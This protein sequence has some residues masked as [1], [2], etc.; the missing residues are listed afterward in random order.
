[1]AKVDIVKEKILEKDKKSRYRKTKETGKR[2]IRLE[3]CS[4][5]ALKTRRS[6]LQMGV[7]MCCIKGIFIF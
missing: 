2:E 3:I 1:M 6:Y 4:F 7:L 5:G